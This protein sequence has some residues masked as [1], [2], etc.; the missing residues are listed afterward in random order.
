MKN[1]VLLILN[2][3]VIL[4]CGTMLVLHFTGIVEMKTKGFMKFGIMLVSYV[5]GVSNYFIKSRA[6]L[7]KPRQYAEIYKDLLQDA[8]SNDK[9]GYRKLIRG[10]DFYQNDQLNKAIKHL[11]KLEKR[12]ITSHDTSA[13]LFFIAKCYQEKGEY[14]KAIATYERLLKING[15]CSAAWSNLG[16]I[17]LEN[18]NFSDA[19]YALNQ[20][21]LYDPNDS[22]AYCNLANI[23]YKNGEFEKAKNLGVKAFQLNNQLSEAASIT[24][25]CYACLGDIEHAK[26]Y[27][28]IY[29]TAKDNRDLITMVKQQLKSS[30]KLLDTP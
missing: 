19:E 27:C 17:N 6:N 15:S 20:A 8:F 21:L 3:L 2:I 11:T 16:F 1:K 12:C 29:G 5:L 24:A 14:S 30:K 9:G 13:V 18:G 22:Y 25:L 23:L 28:Q 26:K 10:I 7:P 4:F